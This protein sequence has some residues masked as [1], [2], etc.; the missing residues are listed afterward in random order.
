M[1]VIGRFTEPCGCEW[2]R[3]ITGDGTM[4]CPPIRPCA[5]HA[6]IASSATRHEWALSEA[7]DAVDTARPVW[8][9]ATERRRQATTAA[10]ADGVTIYR[11]AQILGITQNAVRQILK[12]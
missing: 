8:D 10:R 4:W 6:P 12:L 7:Q 9:A 3:E 1:T 5:E 2:S 11:I